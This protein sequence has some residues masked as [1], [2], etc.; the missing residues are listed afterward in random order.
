MD[1]C[2]VKFVCG[3]LANCTNSNLVE[4]RDCE[5]AIG[6]AFEEELGAV[7]AREDQPVVTVKMIERF[8]EAFVVIG[9]AYLDRGTYDHVRAVTLE[10]C[11]QV[12]SLRRCTRDNNGSSLKWLHEIVVGGGPLWPPLSGNHA[13]VATEGHPYNDCKIELA[14][15]D[16]NSAASDEP[17]SS[18]SSGDPDNESRRISEPSGFATRP[19]S[20]S[21]PLSRIA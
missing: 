1:V 15:R 21:R 3:A 14:P 12:R 2:V 6:K 8:V 9:F 11:C 4:I 20:F 17:R 13:G 7:G 10:H 5:A 19:S 16:N 18:G